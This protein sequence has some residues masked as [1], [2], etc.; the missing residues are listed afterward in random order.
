MRRALDFSISSAYQKSNVK[1]AHP[2][3]SYLLTVPSDF[4]SHPKREHEDFRAK[5]LILLLLDWWNIKILLSLII[6]LKSMTGIKH[7]QEKDRSWIKF[8]WIFFI[9]T[10]WLK[11]YI[12]Y[13][14]LWNKYI[15]SITQYC[16]YSS[17]EW[18]MKKVTKFA[19][20]LLLSYHIMELSK[21]F[22]TNVYLFN[23]EIF[24]IFVIFMPKVSEIISLSRRATCQISI[25]YQSC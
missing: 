2:V 10:N 15:T 14:T 16:L 12:H 6:I 17:M 18:Q 21:T 5:I 8:W 20:S 9:V 23:M 25:F 1:Q 19:L 24:K 13:N 7:G 11:Q 4:L 3:D 22:L